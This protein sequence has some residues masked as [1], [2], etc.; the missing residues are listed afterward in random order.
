MSSR[1]LVKPVVPTTAWM[2]FSIANRRLSITTSG[3][4]KSTT[5]CASARSRQRIADV[6]G[7]DQVEIRRRLDRAHTCWPMRPRAPST[8]TRVVSLIASLSDR[9]VE[10]VRAERPDD[11]QAPRTRE[12]LGSDLGDVGRRDRVDLAEQLVEPEHVAVTQ[13][14]LADT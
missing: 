6:D 5:T 1:S 10:V 14:A 13:F 8:P 3:W 9:A 2:P 11:G 12:H 7:R 4:V